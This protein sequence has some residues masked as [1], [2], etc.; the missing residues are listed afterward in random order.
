MEDNDIFNLPIIKT[1]M[2]WMV[3]FFL[4]L[5]TVKLP[6]ICDNDLYLL[7]LIKSAITGNNSIKFYLTIYTAVWG[8]KCLFSVEL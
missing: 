4:I 6:A 3:N 5:W 8:N 1:I 7:Q 2:R